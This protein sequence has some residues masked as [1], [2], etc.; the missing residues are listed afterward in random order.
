MGQIRKRTLIVDGDKNFATEFAHR[1]TSARHYCGFSQRYAAK[2]LEI[3]PGVLC[4]FEK[5]ISYPSIN[6]LHRMCI[7][8][9]CSADTLLL[10]DTNDL[11]K[12]LTPEKASIL[13]EVV[14][15]DI[16]VS[17]IPVIK[18][19]NDLPQSDFEFLKSVI[20]REYSRCQEKTE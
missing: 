20:E 19:L 9:Q 10:T 18:M 7:L 2:Q 11:S 17:M 13:R 5:G 8:Y 12:D 1:L 15:M 14:A 16:N 3:D 6:T 4:R